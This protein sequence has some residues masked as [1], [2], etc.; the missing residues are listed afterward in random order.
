MWTEGA[1]VSLQRP[2]AEPGSVSVSFAVLPVVSRVL[3]LPRL[4]AAADYA[5]V[6]CR[7][8]AVTS[9]FAPDHQRLLIFRWFLLDLQCMIANSLLRARRGRRKG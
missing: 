2:E 1:S 6:K 5:A 8:F 9:F 7:L 4:P 3:Q